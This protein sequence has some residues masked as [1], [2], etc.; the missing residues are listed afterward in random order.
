MGRQFFKKYMNRKQKTV[1]IGMAGNL[2]LAISKTILSF[3]SGSAAL[4][5]DALHSFSDLLVS[6]LVLAGLKFNK[7]KIESVVTFI[8]GL[9]IISIAV[10]F[11]VELFIKESAIIKN[12]SWAVSGQIIIIIGTYILYRYKTVIGKEENSQSIIADGA[13]TKS[14]MLSSIGVLVS[15]IGSLIGLNLDK[16]AAF[17][18]FFLILYQ[19]LETII[20][21][22]YLFRGVENDS[23]H[24]YHLPLERKLKKIG[25]KLILFLKN[26]RKRTTI[27]TIIALVF[28]YLIPGFYIV[29]QSEEAVKTSFGVLKK[30]TVKAGIHLDPFYPF[31]TTEIVNTGQIN[32][33]EY[34]FRFKKSEVNDVLISQL[35]TIHNSRKFNVI[36]SEENILSGDGSIINITLILEYIISYP[37]DYLFSTNSPESIL[38]IETGS[39]LQKIAGSISLFDV[40]NKERMTIEN[41]LK[42]QI[43][44][45]MKSIKTGLEVID[46][47]LYS[48]TPHLD[49]VYMYRTVQDEEEYKETL[50]F[51]AQAIK[52]KQLPYYRGLAYEKIADAQAEAKEIILEAERQVA[53]YKLM[54]LE[55]MNNRDKEALTYK[56]EL[57][58]RTEVLKNSEKILIEK[59]LKDDLIKI[60]Q[61]SGE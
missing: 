35:E 1:I 22:I 54:E 17:I 9:L 59:N 16:I 49:T 50:I 13:H 33:M 37:I 48:I 52:E 58:A 21:S 31:S 10:G 11:A 24:V 25:M 61:R 40:L 41:Q 2:I 38:R 47:H 28:L 23:L 19:G 14:D 53:L 55:Y 7:K 51:D 8:V 12:I 26:N 20:S 30:N 43:N 44:D 29:D 5:A 27:S 15:L 18:I 32:T 60:D 57:D 3:L 45:S 39:Q 46:V 6:I 42:V 56:L 4:I 36:D 34:G